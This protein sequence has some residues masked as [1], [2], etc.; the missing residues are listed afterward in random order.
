MNHI[1]TR[2]KAKKILRLCVSLM[3]MCYIVLAVAVVKRFFWGGNETL[4]VILCALDFADQVM[5]M[6]VMDE[7]EK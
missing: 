7:V 2:R 3:A 6:K 5:I 4:F 1:K